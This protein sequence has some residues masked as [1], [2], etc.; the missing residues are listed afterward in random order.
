MLIAMES[1]QFPLLSPDMEAG[2]LGAETG[3]LMRRAPET[4]GGLWQR[5]H[6]GRASSS[7]L[8]A[9]TPSRKHSP[10]L[11]SPLLTWQPPT[12]LDL[13]PS[14]ATYVSALEAP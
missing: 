13:L 8:T 2:W 7:R 5:T 14:R 1:N 3:F 4:A 11:T 12:S 6:G 10:L 9:L